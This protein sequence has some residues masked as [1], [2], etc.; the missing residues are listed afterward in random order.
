VSE[1]D[2][3]GRYYDS[4]IALPRYENREAIERAEADRIARAL[5]VVIVAGAM[6]RRLGGEAT[7]DE[8]KVDKR[9][10]RRLGHALQQALRGWTQKQVSDLAALDDTIR[11]E[12][13]TIEW[14]SFLQNH[15]SVINDRLRVIATW[16]IRKEERRWGRSAVVRLENEL[17]WTQYAIR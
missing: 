17:R 4:G 5:A 3:L 9:N 1:L 11:R 6:P 10:A 15:V 12:G 8:L 13:A 7:D 14:D 2:Y 16:S